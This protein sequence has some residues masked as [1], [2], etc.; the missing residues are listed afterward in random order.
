MPTAH[1]R[2]GLNLRQKRRYTVPIGLHLNRGPRIVFGAR[3]LGFNPD[4]VA[5]TARETLPVSN[6]GMITPTSGNNEKGPV[7]SQT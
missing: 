4:E 1:D 6:A 2:V 3:I 7:T 5:V